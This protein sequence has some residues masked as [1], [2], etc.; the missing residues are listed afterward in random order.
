MNCYGKIRNVSRETI[1][2]GD[3]M[4]HW[5]EMSDTEK[6]IENLFRLNRDTESRLMELTIAV[7]DSMKSLTALVH[8]IADRVYIIEKDNRDE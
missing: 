8:N 1:Y 7:T 4:K 5:E 3:N 2:E 6:Q